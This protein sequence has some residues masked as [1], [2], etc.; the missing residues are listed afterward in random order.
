ML[1][2]KLCCKDITLP[3]LKEVRYL[4]WL[5][6]EKQNDLEL[7]TSFYEGCSERMPPILLCWLMMSGADGAD[8]EVESE[9]SHQYSITRC[10]CGTDGSRGAVW[11]YGDW[12]GSVYGGAVCH[13]IPPR[14][15]KGTHWHS[16]MLAESTSG[17]PTVDVSTARPWVVC[18]SCGNSDSGTSPDADFYQCSMQAPVRHWQKCTANGG[19]A[20]LKICVL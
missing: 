7:N 9:P 15:K 16:P 1:K 2:R 20:V 3:R 11:Q 14:G 17:D 4:W 6:R 10:C 12:D 13:R 5:C 19:G 18:F 8:M